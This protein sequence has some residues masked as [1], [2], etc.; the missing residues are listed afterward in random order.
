MCL[1]CGLAEFSKGREKKQ[2]VQNGHKRD[3][4]PTHIPALFILLLF[5]CKH[6]FK[7]LGWRIP[8]LTNQSK[9][10]SKA[11]ASFCNH[12]TKV[13]VKSKVNTTR[14]PVQ[15]RRLIMTLI[16]QSPLPPSEPQTPAPSGSLNG[17]VWTLI[18]TCGVLQSTFTP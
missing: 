2:S 9:K 7:S 1:L 4:N 10:Q 3:L 12:E 13:T 14:V 11:N 18:R 15:P 6:N 17:V 5:K 8:S 16:K